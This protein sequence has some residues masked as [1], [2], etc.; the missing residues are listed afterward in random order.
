MRCTFFMLFC[1]VGMTFANDGYAQKTMLNITLNNR[2]VDEVLTE[3]EQGTEFVFFYNNKQVDVD[4]RVSVKA[5]N[6]T[7]FK[8]LDEVFK[9]T[10]ITYKVLDRNIILY[11]K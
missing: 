10:N 5:N 8:V 2:T 7:I 3:L 6:K 11:D 4:R 9:G 1:L